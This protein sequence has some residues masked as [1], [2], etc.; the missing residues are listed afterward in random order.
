[1]E[2]RNTL[3]GAPHLH[4]LKAFV[5]LKHWLKHGEFV[6]DDFPDAEITILAT[7]GKLV[8]YD[9]LHRDVFDLRLKI[10]DDGDNKDHLSQQREP[11]L[12]REEAIELYCAHIEDFKLD[13]VDTAIFPMP[14]PTPTP[15]QCSKTAGSSFSS[16]SSS[17]AIA[18]TTSTSETV[19]MAFAVMQRDDTAVM[20]HLRLQ[21]ILA[22]IPQGLRKLPVWIQ[23]P[24][25]GSFVPC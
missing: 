11:L 16:A 19:L 6:P 25:P 13:D 17:S 24:K 15:L 14:I 21:N 3:L 1:M 10:R 23:T 8:R 22:A 20:L 5:E 4:E 2:E 7:D 12:T 9:V 18:T